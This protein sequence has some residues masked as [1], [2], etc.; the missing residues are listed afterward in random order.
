MKKYYLQFIFINILFYII[1]FIPV[2]TVR[3]DAKIKMPDPQIK[4]SDELTQ[5]LA[6]P[7][8]CS[9]ING[10]TICK[11][12]W[13]ADYI[14]AVYKYLIGIVGILATVVMMIGGVI[15]I[16]AGGNAS[17]VGEAKAW[18]GG[19]LMGLVLALAS[20]TI[21]YQINDETVKMKPIKYTKVNGEDNYSVSW[22]EGEDYI[23][24][25][26]SWLEGTTWVYEC[27][28]KLKTEGC[29]SNSLSLSTWTK[30][31]G[32]CDGISGKCE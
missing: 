2:N 28:N 27:V 17:R 12:S 8:D 18:I 7:P 24:C 31:N 10:K 1:L 25:Q 16:T 23:C 22:D 13:I 14:E 30:K 20:Y 15:W 19:A 4:I 6:T 5:K 21:L 9:T 26:K 32:A 3:A 11:N 29:P